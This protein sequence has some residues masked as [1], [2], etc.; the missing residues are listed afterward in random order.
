MNRRLLVSVQPM[1]DLLPAMHHLLL[2]SD[3]PMPNFLPALEPALR[4][5][6]VTL[7]VSDPMR[8]K[9][10]ALRTEFTHLGIPVDND[11]PIGDPSDIAAIEATI[12]AWIDAHAGEDIVLNLTGGTKPMSIASQEAFRMAG[13]PA[14][15]VD[16]RTDRAT[17]IEPG[18][19]PIPLVNQ[20]TLGQFFRINGTEV[21]FHET[22]VELPNAKWSTLAETFAAD[23]SRWQA[24]LGYLSKLAAEAEQDGRLECGRPG[25]ADTVERWDELLEELYG[26]ELTRSNDGKLSFRSPV[27]RAFCQGIWFEHLVFS[28]L[29]ARPFDGKRLWRNVKL[30]GAGDESNELDIAAL[31]RNTLYIVECKARNMTRDGVVDAAVYKLA[32]LARRNGLRARGILASARPVRPADKRRAAAYGI[33]V[34]DKPATLDAQFR[35]LFPDV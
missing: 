20:P 13:Q 33:E 30:L 16:I 6:R 2:V 15:Y 11:I 10:D 21:E 23:I 34:L 29:R 5:D 35:R 1:P 17:F 26:N 3:Q 28:R 14:F 4:P 18:R 7:A 19:E 22:S 25:E 24:P 31:Y 8:L 27:A 32:E 9:A 12:V